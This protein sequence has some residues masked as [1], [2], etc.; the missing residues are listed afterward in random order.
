MSC[1]KKQND[2]LDGYAAM[3]VTQLRQLVKEQYP[4]VK[5]VRLLNRDELCA[6]LNKDCV[7]M[8]GLTNKANSCYLDSALIS[9]LFMNCPY[10]HNEILH[11]QLNHQDPEL[12][13]CAL[14]IQRMLVTIYDAIEKGKRGACSKLREAFELFDTMYADKI[15][16]IE[17]LDWRREQLEPAD[18]F[19]FLIRVFQIG[20]DCEYEFKSYSVAKGHKTPLT[21]EIRKGTFADCMIGIDV[22]SKDNFSDLSKYVPKHTER[23]RILKRDVGDDGILR[24]MIVKKYVKAP[25]F[26][27]HVQRVMSGG[28]IQTPIVPFPT[29]KLKNNENVLHLRAVIVHHGSS[30]DHGHYTSYLRCKQFWYHYD[31]LAFEKMV[32]IGSTKQLFLQNKNYV[33][34]NCVNLIYF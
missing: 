16:K 13:T 31:D 15:G 17:K 3:S 4:Y 9:L 6:L 7:G 5:Q 20:D 21:D 27:V 28:K 25:L 19:K 2:A 33:L 22:L 29:L 18:V 12:Q 32:K 23:I 34:R 30:A 11:K 14:R 10:I 26:T 8:G 1:G 24:K